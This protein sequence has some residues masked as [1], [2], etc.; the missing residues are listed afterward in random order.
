MTLDAHCD[1][2][3]PS[4]IVAQVH[5]LFE[6]MCL[7]GRK[8]ERKQQPREGWARRH[9]TGVLRRGV[10][11]ASRR[12]PLVGVQTTGCPERW[13]RFGF[14]FP[15][16]A[17]KPERCL[18]SDLLC[19][20]TMRLGEAREILGLTADSTSEDARKA[21]RRLALT[22]H[23]DKSTA[24]DA[25]EQFQRIQADWAGRRG[26]RRGRGRRGAVWA[27]RAWAQRAPSPLWAPRD[28]S[29]ARH[30][31]GACRTPSPQDAFT[32]IQA[33]EESGRGGGSE[34]EYDDDD[35]Y[36][37][38]Y[39]DDYEVRRGRREARAHRPRS[40]ARCP[41]RRRLRRRH[42]C[43]CSPSAATRRLGSAA[44]PSPRPPRAAAPRAASPPPEDSRVLRR[45]RARTAA[46]EGAEAGMCPRRCT[47]C[48]LRCDCRDCRAE[49]AAF[50]RQEEAQQAA[51][52]EAARRE[53]ARKRVWAEARKEAAAEGARNRR[54]TVAEPSPP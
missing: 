39:D 29:A 38:Y 52:R 34:D 50:A 32:R 18:A 27:G 28:R 4:H 10:W 33:S 9:H 41:R 30:S 22:A 1:H 16:E 17:A 53:A 14:L 23:P 21:Y 45:L 25:T 31:P 36:D 19:G 35:D 46:S 3:P 5:S 11:C 49:R 13:L 43:S 24:P 20:P 15:E 7:N 48:L 44:R 12:P 51:R 2:L 40:A 26:G 8:K 42:S 6:R 37:E 54:G 47:A